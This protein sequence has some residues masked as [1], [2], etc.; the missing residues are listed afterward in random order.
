MKPIL[1]ILHGVSGSA[2]EMAP[3]AK[4]LSA[5]FDVRVPNLLGHGGRPVPEGYALQDMAD[6]LV[7]WLDSE[8]IGPAHFL[9]YS[10]GGYLAFYLARHQPQRVK[11]VSGIV[12][13]HVFDEAALSYI[14]YLAD[15]DRLGRLG[16]PR[17]DELI[18]VHG[19][20]NW[21]NVT[22]NTAAL[23]EGFGRGLPLDE[24]DI[25]AIS[26]PALVLSGD[27]DPLVSEA[28]T[29]A[30]A[31]LLLNARLGLFPG[32]SH[33]LKVVPLLDAVRAVKTFVDEVEHDRFTPGPPLDLGPRLVL[34]GIPNADVKV[35]VGKAK[36]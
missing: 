26:T 34:G 32:P 23:F 30:L 24:S 18:A 15:P 16:N 21:I 28:E 27:R 33:P 9:G 22:K 29:R 4:P 12:V 11:S 5:W 13:K 25:R 19:E 36:D 3:L 6:D 7:S 1:V 20:G 14:A 8:G 35:T 31:A 17:K 10:L 2:G